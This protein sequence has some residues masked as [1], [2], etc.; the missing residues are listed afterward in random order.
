LYKDALFSSSTFILIGILE[1]YILASFN[2]RAASLMTVPL[3]TI[4]M[5][6]FLLLKTLQNLTLARY[7]VDVPKNGT[8]RRREQPICLTLFRHSLVVW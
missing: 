2:F 5:N 6:H 1:E 4:N 8:E 7:R 3:I